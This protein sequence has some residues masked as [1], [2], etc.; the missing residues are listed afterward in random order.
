MTTRTTAGTMNRR[1]STRDVP[2]VI[3]WTEGTHSAG[4]TG[5]VATRRRASNP[6][7]PGNR[8]RTWRANRDSGARGDDAAIGSPALD[9]VTYHLATDMSPPLE[10]PLD[11]PPYDDG[12]DEHGRPGDHPE[13]QQALP[14]R[15]N[16]LPELHET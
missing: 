6:E 7:R 8:R 3:R 15:A 2:P 16:Q 11:D 10:P 13:R 4:G 14:V 5:L 12:P 9:W 1:T